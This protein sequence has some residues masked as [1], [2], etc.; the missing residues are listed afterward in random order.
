MAEAPPRP[1]ATLDRSWS[2]RGPL[3]TAE[4]P[5]RVCHGSA[6]AKATVAYRSFSSWKFT[7]FTAAYLSHARA[8]NG[9]HECYERA[10]KMYICAGNC[11][12]RVPL[13]D[14]RSRSTPRGAYWCYIVDPGVSVRRQY[15]A[16]NA[17]KWKSELHL[18]S[19]ADYFHRTW[20]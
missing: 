5:S 3:G 9:M 15:S 10:R 18:P 19:P 11:V 13:A 2:A 16:L 4:T 8:A 6:L 12:Y 7:A 14:R 17:H 20:K 1:P